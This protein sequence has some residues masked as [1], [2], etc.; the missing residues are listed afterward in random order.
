MRG[1]LALALVLVVG[2]ARPGGAA[3]APERPGRVAVVAAGAA[4][5]GARDARAAATREATSRVRGELAAA[6]LEVV[7]VP[8]PA[9][10]LRAGLA[11]AARAVGA[12]GA[13]AIVGTADGGAEI[14]IHDGDDGLF[15]QRLDRATDPPDFASSILAVRSVE[16]LRAHLSALALRAAPPDPAPAPPGVQ[17]APQARQRDAPRVAGELGLSALHGVH[18]LGTT[19]SPALTLVGQVGPRLALRLS[20]AGLGTRRT[21]EAPPGAG[22]VTQGLAMGSGLVRLGARGPVAAH[23]AAGAGAYRLGVRGAPRS[24]ATRAARDAA[25]AGALG[26]GA[27]LS[28]AL[29]R[30][31]GLT[32][33]AQALAFLPSV[34]VRLDDATPARAAG[35]TVQIV[36][37]LWAALF[38]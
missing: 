25:W 18:G 13:V 8:R 33:E 11:P 19:L 22:E 12:L 23:V 1:A 35:P 16:L 7:L 17:A 5:P 2:A 24:A 36:V 20:V 28:L 21:V 34:V 30:R 38:E 14:W 15:V 26:G 6:G 10:E 3:P 27:G 9:G 31:V 37:G 4:A 32:A 29:G